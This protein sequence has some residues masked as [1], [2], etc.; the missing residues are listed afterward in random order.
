MRILVLLKFLYK[1]VT[2]SMKRVWG[3]KRDVNIFFS[4]KN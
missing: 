1:V 4:V 3:K 2:Y